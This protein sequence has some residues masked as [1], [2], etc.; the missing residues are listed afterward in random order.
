MNFYKIAINSLRSE[1]ESA[2]VYARLSSLIKDRELSEKLKN[3]A[4]MEG[5]H[6]RFWSE[7]LKSRNINIKNKIPSRF[8]ISV[9]TFLLRVLGIGLTVKL[10]ELGEKEAIE[11]YAKLLSSEEL[12]SEERVR[13]KNIIEDELFHEEEFKG[14][15]SR[16]KEF[17]D[18]IRDAVLG[19]NDGLVE[20]LSVSAGLA[21]AYGNPLY[22][23]LG[24]TIVGISGA[25]SMGVGTFVSVKAQRDVRLGILERI[26]LT[27]RLVGHLLTTRV[28]SYYMKRGFSESTS[29]SVA[30]EAGKKPELLGKL[31]GEEEYG[32]KEEKLESPFLAGLYTGIFYVLGAFLPLIPY[33]LK[34][35][36]LHALPISFLIAGT[37]LSISGAL[38]A[39]I[40]G[41][42]IARRAIEL[43][44]SGLGSAV[45]TY[46]IGLAASV[47]LGINV[48]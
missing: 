27:A 42:H 11:T 15:S 25:L 34:A 37:M 33:F 22:V 21:G 12:S 14:E 1:L 17:L 43:V 20:V 39:I 47:I 45:V 32:L 5:R 2:A 4:L 28:K 24:G 18:H 46:L 3:M 13:L 7:F 31:I 48:T 16:F 40:A 10:L 38:I 6:A 19:M 30:Q 44:I 23:A 29:E 41:L 8:S 9:K 26:K 36:V 35:P